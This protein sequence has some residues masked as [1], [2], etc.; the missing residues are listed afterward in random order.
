[1]IRQFPKPCPPVRRSA[2]RSK[3]SVLPVD[4]HV[5]GLPAAINLS[6]E[7]NLPFNFDAQRIK[8]RNELPVHS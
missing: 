3:F 6:H 7:Q 5:L 1:S 8:L 2:P 4:F